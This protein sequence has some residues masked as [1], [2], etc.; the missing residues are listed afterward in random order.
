MN[1]RTSIGLTA[2]IL[3][4]SGSLILYGANAEYPADQH[5]PSDIVLI[6]ETLVS[7]TPSDQNTHSTTFQPPAE[8]DMPKDE[9]GKAVQ[10]GK[11]IFTHTDVY[12]SQF[13]GTNSNLR[14]SS[15]H[16]DAG[17]LA[18]SAPLWGAY[19][20]YPTYRSKNK[21]VNTYA[22]RMQGCFKFSMNG[23]APPLGDPVLVA[24][25]SYSYWLA[26]G[27]K[28]DPKIKGRGYPKLPK[29]ALPQDYAR[30][31]KVYE[32]YCAL[33]H[34]VDGAGQVSENNQPN[35][36]ALWGDKSFNWGAGMSSIKNAAGFIKANMPLGLGNTL[37]VQQAWDVATF[38][39][40]HERPQDPRYKGS[41][42]QTRAEHHDS[43]EDMYGTMVNGYLL[44]SETLAKSTPVKG[45]AK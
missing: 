30:G 37:T 17:R 32:Q 13:V 11:D 20:S 29:P 31:Q 26:T 39:D 40:S 23:K 15:C 12:A 2:G 41:V 7:G 36:P 18:D 25:E 10:L 19:V 16:L 33:C 45:N 43:D 27:A 44:G 3:I 6:K 35:F 9:F 42:A 34:G 8:K 4:L 28:I 38:M 24:L 14:C 22:E 21:H 1:I 5:K